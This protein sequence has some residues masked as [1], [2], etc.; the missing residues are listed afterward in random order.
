MSRADKA[1]PRIRSLV[2]I[3]M[4]GEPAR[5]VAAQSGS[6]PGS[7]S[8]YVESLEKLQVTVVFDGHAS[9]TL[10]GEY[11][12]H[13]ARRDVWTADSLVLGKVVLKLARQA[14]DHESTVN[15]QETNMFDMMG[16]RLRD[17]CARI[18]FNEVDVRVQLPEKRWM[19]SLARDL[20]ETVAYKINDAAEPGM[21][22]DRNETGSVPGKLFHLMLQERAEDVI[23]YVNRPHLAYPDGYEDSIK[24]AHELFKMIVALCRGI[25]R[26]SDSLRLV[27]CRT[28]KLGVRMCSAS[29]GARPRVSGIVVI[30]VDAIVIRMP[31]SRAE[32]KAIRRDLEQKWRRALGLS[33]TWGDARSSTSLQASWDLLSCLKSL[34]MMHFAEPLYSLGV[35]TKKDLRLLNDKDLE[36]IGMAVVHIRKIRVATGAM[37]RAAVSPS[38]PTSSAGPASSFGPPS[39]S[40]PSTSMECLL[41]CLGLICCLLECLLERLRTTSLPSGMPT[42]T[43]TDDI[44]AI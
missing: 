42:G 44:V 7:M 34:S 35:A 30:D 28:A 12:S 33:E 31:G 41:K 18:Y 36:S 29:S 23:E 39:S 13:G 40:G 15:R 19:H 2:D 21:R 25:E 14:V 24:V 6:S 26:Q 32:P 37:K 3:S 8:L 10:V 27:D 16:K 38:G 17:T 5:V 11:Y 22:L 20:P 1:W 9:E 4:K 43:P